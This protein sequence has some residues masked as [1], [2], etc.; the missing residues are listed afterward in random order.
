[1]RALI[2]AAGLGTRLRPL[3]RLRAKAALP[4]NGEP[5]V[6]RIARTLAARGFRD[7]V[8]N[9]HHLPA[10]ITRLIGDGADLGVRVRYSWEHPVLGSA[11][12]PRHALPLLVDGSRDARERFLLVNGDTLTDADPGELARAHERAGDAA[13][14][15]A[16]IPNPRPDKYGGVLVEGDRVTG[17]SRPGTAERSYHFIG[18]QV[19][20]ARAF[21]SL[22]DGQPIESV[23]NVYPRLLAEDPR[24]ICAFISG[25]AFQ[26]IGTPADYLTT[27]VE[28]AAAEGNRLV[29][30]VR[31][32]VHPSAALTDT[33]VWDDVTIG[34][35]ARIEESIVCDG[36]R[37]PAGARYV[38]CAILPAGGQAPAPGE[39]V[40]GD[41]LISPF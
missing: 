31:V 22:P 26:D 34:P 29:S 39:R 7:L 16:L 2:L 15:M 11:G 38:R 9:L 21:A 37:V 24:A 17:F 41:L 14:T 6:R 5:L 40:E 3:T 28:L 20:E 30:G 10:T 35:G 32:D 1:V 25:A 36:A 12:G 23:T 27:S 18:L 4:V 8:V 19:A 33:A 13:V